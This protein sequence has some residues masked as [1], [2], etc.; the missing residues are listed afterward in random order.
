MDEE[1]IIVNLEFF[2]AMMMTRDF[3]RDFLE[4]RSFIFKILESKGTDWMI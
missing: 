2:R 1:L 3:F 4:I